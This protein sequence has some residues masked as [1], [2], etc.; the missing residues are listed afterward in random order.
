M[1][2]VEA[3]P[4]LD[5]ADLLQ[6]LRDL[7]E[8]AEDLRRRAPPLLD[9]LAERIL[10][11]VP[12]A[13]VGTRHLVLE[14]L[15]LLLRFLCVRDAIGATLPRVILAEVHGWRIVVGR[16]APALLIETRTLTDAELCAMLRAMRALDYADEHM[17]GKALREA[18]P[19]DLIELLEHHHAIQAGLTPRQLWAIL[20]VSVR[21]VA[22]LVREPT[23]I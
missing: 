14:A 10:R 20:G 12:I 11:Y 13:E 5:A 23:G 9:L 22:R 2:A 6:E 19:A 4:D 17:T 1:P 18:M 8:D 7:A 21:R 15:G 3:G 16:A